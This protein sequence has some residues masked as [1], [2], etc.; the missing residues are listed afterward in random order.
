MPNNAVI[1]DRLPWKHAVYC[2]IKNLISPIRM[3][4]LLTPD[5]GTVL[6]IGCG[7]GFSTHLIALNK[8]DI[9]VEGI[10][11]D[12]NKI[13]IALT[14]F[15]NDNKIFKIEDARYMK[16]SNAY[17]AVVVSDTFYLISPECQAQL[18]KKISRS[19]KEKGIFILKEID[20]TPQWKFYFNYIQETIMVKG[21]R[22]TKG[23]TF[24]FMSS[25]FYQHLFAHNGLT[26]DK[27]ACHH[28]YCYPHVYYIG[29]K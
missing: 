7:I 8:R 11:I 29:Q 3:L 22:F 5:T 20:Q 15:G 23:K 19:L 21:V 6:D 12:E 10:D 18:T 9:L 28:G 25:V 4:N 27:R 24:H 13:K 17:D 1:P 26:F 16:I 2:R 14:Y